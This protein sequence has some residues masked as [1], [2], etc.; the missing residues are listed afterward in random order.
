LVDNRAKAVEA[1]KKSYIVS[2]RS[3]IAEAMDKAGIN[4]AFQT[5]ATIL[6]DYYKQQYTSPYDIATLFIHA[7]KKEESIYWLGR[8]IE[9]VDPR[10]HFIDVDPDWDVIKDDPRFIKYLKIIG[11]RQ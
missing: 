11:F 9:D 2:G 5:A 10:L 3:V 8:S 4:N 7:G 1:C 6:A